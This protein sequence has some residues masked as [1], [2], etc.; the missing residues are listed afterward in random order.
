MQNDAVSVSLVIVNVL[1][2]FWLVSFL[3]FGV[4]LA[5]IFTKMKSRVKRIEQSINGSPN[6]STLELLKPREHLTEAEVIQIRDFL[7]YRA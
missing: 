4:L 7:N 1:A 5:V 3:M 2:V 6:F